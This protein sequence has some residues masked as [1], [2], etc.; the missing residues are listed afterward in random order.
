MIYHLRFTVILSVVNLLP[1]NVAAGRRMS[2]Y[3]R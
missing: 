1:I 3:R 2:E